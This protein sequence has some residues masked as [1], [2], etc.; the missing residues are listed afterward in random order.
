MHWGAYLNRALFII[1][2]Q[3][4]GHL[5]IVFKSWFINGNPNML[6]TA[7]NRGFCVLEYELHVRALPG[8][9][10]LF[11]RS[12]YCSYAQQTK[13]VLLTSPYVL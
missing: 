11:L 1:P 5:Q 9:H 3:F 10:L 4:R 12:H 6:E 2:R 7:Q 8:P 13:F